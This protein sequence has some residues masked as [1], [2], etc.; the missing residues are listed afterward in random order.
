MQPQAK[1]AKESLELPEAGPEA[2]RIVPQGFQE[3]ATL[4]TP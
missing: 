1:E 3:G 4:P 2:P